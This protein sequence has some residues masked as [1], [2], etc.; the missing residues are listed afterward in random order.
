MR[1][2]DRCGEGVEVGLDVALH[3][4]GATLVGGPSPG[5]GPVEVEG[6]DAEHH[7]GGQVGRQPC[8]DV[9][10]QAQHD[11]AVEVRHHPCGHPVADRRQPGVVPG[12]GP[13]EGAAYP[14]PKH[15]DVVSDRSA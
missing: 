15:V 13:V 6:V 8:P 12:A 1:A 11:P 7:V 3:H 5:Q 9:G 10:L 4:P 2:A 14:D